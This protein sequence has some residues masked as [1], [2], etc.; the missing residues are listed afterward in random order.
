L[1]TADNLAAQPIASRYK[2]AQ[3]VALGRTRTVY[4]A[5][6]L[7]IG[8][9]VVVKVLREMRPV[10]SPTDRRLVDEARIIGQ[11]Q[12]LG[13]S[14]V[15]DVGDLPDGRPFLVMKLIRGTTMREL[16]HERRDPVRDCSRF[17][18]VFE[19]LAQTLAYAH[20]KGVIHGDLRPAKVMVGAFGGVQV[21]GWGRCKVPGTLAATGGELAQRQA[22][23]SGILADARPEQARMGVTD[24]RGDV[25]GLGE[26]LCAIL[27]G[28]LP[29]SGLSDNEGM[30]SKSIR[31]SSGL[32][33]R[34]E[35][36]GA[37]A[38][39]VALAKRCLS[40]TPADRPANAAEVAELVVAYRA[41]A[42]ESLR[43]AEARCVT[44]QVR[45]DER[46]KRRWVL[47]AL[48]AAV[49]LLV[50]ACIARA[51]GI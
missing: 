48:A 28:A 50:V 5:T 2:I 40:P 20:A 47:L 15:H 39:L 45:A 32:T 25:F 29:S 13:I 36:C 1:S 33:A 14:P 6:D 42:E 41:A 43:E 9:D 11:L 46:R 27:T 7:A 16:L 44:A 19:Q 26:S 35:E 10:D 17:L 8:C 22:S 31:D 18:A 30:R 23:A 12:H 21:I 34:L 3:V 38:E 49:G 24:F 37:G 4:R 51:L